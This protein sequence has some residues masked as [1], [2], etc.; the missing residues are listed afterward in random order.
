[1]RQKQRPAHK[2]WKRLSLAILCSTEST[3]EA[4]LYRTRVEGER[5][6]RKASMYDTHDKDIC[7]TCMHHAYD[8]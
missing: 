8:D 1:M 5:I 2:V 4:P 6:A 3:T 7:R